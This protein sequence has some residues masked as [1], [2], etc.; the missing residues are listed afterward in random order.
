MLKLKE[1]KKKS[2]RTIA[3]LE[4]TSFFTITRLQQ[5]EFERLRKHYVLFMD[6]IQVFVVGWKKI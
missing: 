5:S 4:L 2:E 6:F 1:K 3:M